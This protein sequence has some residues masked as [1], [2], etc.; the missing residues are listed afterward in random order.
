MAANHATNSGRACN[1]ELARPFFLF[2]KA[3]SACALNPFVELFEN[4]I[5]QGINCAGAVKCC[6]Q[7][8][9]HKRDLEAG[10]RC[11]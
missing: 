11:V 4:Q 1:K 8:F 9:Q 2:C 3:G 7:E 5:Q 6:D 10:F